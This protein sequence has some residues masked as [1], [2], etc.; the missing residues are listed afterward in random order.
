VFY[1]RQLGKFAS[2]PAQ[3]RALTYANTNKAFISPTELARVIALCRGDLQ[4]AA[5][6]SDVFVTKDVHD[7]VFDSRV[8][9]TASDLVWAVN[10]YKAASRGVRNFF[11]NNRVHRESEDSNQ[12]LTKPLARAGIHYVCMLWLAQRNFELSREYA[13]KL[14]KVHQLSST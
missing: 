10:C 1:E 13:V 5:K 8:L 2:I 11:E 12:L 4:L 9:R 6:P 7:S 3:R 14:N